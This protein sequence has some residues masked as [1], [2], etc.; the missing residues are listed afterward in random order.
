ATLLSETDIKEIRESRGKIPNASKKMAKKFYI[1]PKY[2][3]EIWDNK[4][5]LQQ[6]RDQV[7][8]SQ[9]E[10]VL[11][12]GSKVGIKPESQREDLWR[13]RDQEKT[14]KKKLKFKSALALL[15][16]STNQQTS[17]SLNNLYINKEE[18]DASYEKMA[19]FQ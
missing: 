15:I 9:P 13:D 3:Y 19:S 6:G 1:G 4:K 2:V 16:S 5:H 10:E 11:K 17:T 18:L 14:G 7:N 8:P 12:G